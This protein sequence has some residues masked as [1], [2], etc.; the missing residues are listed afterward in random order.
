MSKFLEPISLGKLD[1]LYDE[2]DMVPSYTRI[3]RRVRRGVARTK[4]ISDRS[5]T[6]SVQR[7]L[8]SSKIASVRKWLDKAEKE[9]L[10]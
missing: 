6:N 3:I 10:K 1:D 2:I 8:V 7:R 9:L 4:F 5:Q